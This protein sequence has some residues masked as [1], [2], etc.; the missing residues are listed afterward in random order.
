MS[1]TNFSYSE[2]LCRLPKISGL[3]QFSCGA[4][5]LLFSCNSRIGITPA[6]STVYRTLEG[7]SK[8]EAELTEAIGRDLEKWLYGRFDNVQS[9]SKRR[10]VRIGRTNQMRIGTAG[11]AFEME[12][13]DPRA[14][15]VDDR[16]RRVKECKRADISVD[17]LHKLVDGGHAD[18]MGTAQWLGVLVHYA[19]PL[20]H[21][22]TKVSEFYRTEGSKKQIN[23]QRKTK[24]HPLATNAKNETKTTDLLA[25]L[26]D[27]FGQIGQRNK[28]YIRRLII[29]GGD[30]LTFEKMVQL[31]QYMQFHDDEFQ[32]LALLVPILEL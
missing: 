23:P 2:N 9:Y 4:S 5:S 24:M 32:S 22:K 7:L 19:E 13:F 8:Y 12:D 31:K 14:M 26:V 21:F 10:D 15:D 27:F 29:M 20:K 25:A 30:G 28:D 18:K 17:W 6:Y 11:T 3:L 1:S 16:I